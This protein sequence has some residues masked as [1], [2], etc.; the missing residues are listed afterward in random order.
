MDKKTSEND[1]LMSVFKA[2]D[3]MIMPSISQRFEVCHESS[4]YPRYLLQNCYQPDIFVEAVQ[5]R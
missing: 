1:Q 4:P 5:T 2:A 3:K